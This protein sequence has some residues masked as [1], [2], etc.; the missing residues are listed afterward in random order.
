MKELDD[1][2]AELVKRLG[3]Q[4]AVWRRQPGLVL[5]IIVISDDQV[6]T[7]AWVNQHELN[8]FVIGIA[9]PTDVGLSD[10][11]LDAAQTNALVLVDK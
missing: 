9:S 2:N 3:D 10:W 8:S 5:W 1:H 11:R 6:A 7:K 4:Q